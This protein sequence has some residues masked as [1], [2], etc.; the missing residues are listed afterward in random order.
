MIVRRPAPIIIRAYLYLAL[1]TILGFGFGFFGAYINDK[2]TM[3]MSML[4]GAAGIV[5]HMVYLGYMQ[6]EYPEVFA[7]RMMVIRGE[8]HKVYTR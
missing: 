3:I 5:C 2:E 4:I 8:Y 1:Y 6:S 7:D